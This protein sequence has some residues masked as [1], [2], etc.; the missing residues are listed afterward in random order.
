MAISQLRKYRAG[1]YVVLFSSVEIGSNR[2]ANQ[3]HIVR[4][5]TWAWPRHCDSDAMRCVGCRR[6]VLNLLLVEE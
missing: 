4:L 5:S 1:G 3:L 6:M 2:N